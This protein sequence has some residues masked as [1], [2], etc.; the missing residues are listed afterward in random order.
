MA[1]RPFSA[2]WTAALDA[3]VICVS[4]S[5][6]LSVVAAGA[7]DRS[8]T[9]L[10]R[11]GKSLWKARV[12]NEVWAAAVSGDANRIA[13]GTANK[14]PA[15]GAIHVYD[16]N[17]GRLFS[18]SVG[19]PVWSVSLS[20][21]GTILVAGSWDNNLYVFTETHGRWQLK[22]SKCIADRGV[23]GVSV[24]DAGTRIIAVAYGS[25]VK[26]L[27]MNLV[28][29][30]EIKNELLGYRARFSP[31]GDSAIVGMRDGSVMLLN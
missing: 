1:G 23:Y 28:L 2:A 29:V 27:D 21:D 15:E 12:D 25:S 14:S 22:D 19:A 10:D 17:G 8:V 31:D 30:H 4:S 6:N 11:Q 13:V 5:P 18:Y 9:I 7:V 3:S 24:D 20:S 26:P 16:R